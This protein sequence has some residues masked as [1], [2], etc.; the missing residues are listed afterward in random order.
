MASCEGATVGLDGG[1]EDRDDGGG[2]SPRGDLAIGADALGP[3]VD[4][5][6][7]RPPMFDGGRLD[8]GEDADAL[9]LGPEVVPIPP[10]IGEVIPRA[11]DWRRN[12]GVVAFTFE[13]AE[14]PSASLA[15]VS[16]DG[17]VEPWSEDSAPRLEGAEQV[18]LVRAGNAL[19]AAWTGEDFVLRYAPVNA[20]GAIG[21]IQE[22][23][24]PND[25]PALD[26]IVDV[27]AVPGSLFFVTTTRAE[28]SGPRRVLRQ[29]TAGGPASLWP[30]QI[31]A[32]ARR[33]FLPVQD[34]S[35]VLALWFEESTEIAGRGTLR[36]RSFAA[37]GVAVGSERILS[38]YGNEMES[39]VFGSA[40]V[41]GA[42]TTDTGLFVVIST[43]G[44]TH[45]TMVSGL[46]FN[47]VAL[48][49]G[50]IDP[51]P[52]LGSIYE[53]HHASFLRG[54]LNEIVFGVHHPTSNP[55]RYWVDVHRVDPHRDLLGSARLERTATVVAFDDGFAVSCVGEDTTVLGLRCRKQ[56]IP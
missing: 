29:S 8:L 11:L 40:A 18:W 37:D 26:R 42:S 22:L 25:A 47:S 31:Q 30:L 35:N 5:A 53:F 48:S 55:N 52:P 49:Q 19:Y 46:K 2:S 44:S 21:A 14:G 16:G 41:L 10:A 34:A 28:P 9:D 56:A 6:A 20:E 39:E 51:W 27:T 38:G 32:N 33:R 15:R 17:L 7:D 13:T 36:A 12:G 24:L 50:R 4:P 54:D 23:E 45:G 3:D 43:A 1:T